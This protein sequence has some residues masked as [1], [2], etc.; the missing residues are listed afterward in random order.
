MLKLLDTYNILKMVE[1]PK[2]TFEPVV[3]LFD[4]SFWLQFMQVS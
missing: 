2:E 3:P 4:I 1:A